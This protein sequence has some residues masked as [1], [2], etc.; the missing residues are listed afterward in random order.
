MATELRDL[1]YEPTQPRL[2]VVRNGPAKLELNQVVSELRLGL[3]LI[4]ETRWEQ[5]RQ[6]RALAYAPVSSQ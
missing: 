5:Q 6:S 4:R 2:R 1:D 3:R